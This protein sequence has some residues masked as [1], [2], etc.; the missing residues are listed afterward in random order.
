MGN[1]EKVKRIYSAF[2][3][4]DVPGIL[5]ELAQDVVW[6]HDAPA[7]GLRIFTHGVGHAHV[8]R[9][10]EAVHAELEIVR[11]V[12]TNFLTGADQVA[13]CIEA[14][15]RVR[16]TGRMLST[17]EIQL[18]TFNT[19]GKVSRFFHCLDRHAAVLAFRV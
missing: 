13:A 3:D 15:A 9:Y 5:D 17:L 16:S 1:A 14:E 11:F 4:G 19:S 6:D 12:P 8:R 2:A 10:L 18:W 7:Y